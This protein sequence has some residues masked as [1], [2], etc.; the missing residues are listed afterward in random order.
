MEAGVR[1]VLAS[2]R[3]LESAR[4]FADEIGVNAPIIAYNGALVYD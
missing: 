2:G 3:M 1:V 4:P